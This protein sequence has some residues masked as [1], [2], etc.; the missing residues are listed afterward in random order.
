MKPLQTAL[1]PG[2]FQMGPIMPIRSA[3]VIVIGDDASL[4]VAGITPEM[5]ITRVGYTDI[6]SQARQGEN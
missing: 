1:V 3:S 5:I 6:S 4:P 2:D